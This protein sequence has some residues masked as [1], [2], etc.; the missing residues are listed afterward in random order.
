MDSTTVS[1]IGSA[2][3]FIGSL[4][5]LFFNRRGTRTDTLS[6]L[7]SIIDKVQER[8]DKLYDEKVACEVATEKLRG[9]L[10][11]ALVT[12]ADLKTE[13]AKKEGFIQGITDPL[14]K[15]EAAQK[16]SLTGGRRTTDIK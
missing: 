11:I 12:I 2:L 9:D 5:T 13:L 16:A 14:I 15:L 4:I 10:A 1:L 3:L 7:E 8:A 6:K